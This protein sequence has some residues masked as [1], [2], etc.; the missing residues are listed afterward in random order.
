MK[1]IQDGSYQSLKSIRWGEKEAIW[2]RTNNKPL[3]IK[4]VYLVSER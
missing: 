2:I 4:R 3:V 1:R